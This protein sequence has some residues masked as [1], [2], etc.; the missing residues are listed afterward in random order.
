MNS[1]LLDIPA[2]GGM[3]NFVFSLPLRRLSD[4]EFGTVC[5]ENP[6]LRIEQDRQ[7]NL[8]VLPPVNLASGHHELDLGTQLFRWAE[9][10]GT[11]LAFSSSTLFTLP[12]GAR[13]SPDASWLPFAVWNELSDDERHTFAKVC[14][15]FVIEL[16]SPSDR[17]TALQ[18]KMGEYV[19]N[20]VQLGFLVDP[21]EKTVHIYRPGRVVETLD[22]PPRV[23]GDPEM[24]GLTITLERIL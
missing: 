6:H 10:D 7:G 19:E 2:G 1:L 4:E 11:G 5:R 23:S 9:R 16:R 24:P 12:H 14:P 3:E 22:Q 15:H 17:L 20:G 8:I 13:R 18:E 21:L